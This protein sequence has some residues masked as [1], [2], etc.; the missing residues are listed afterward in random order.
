MVKPRLAAKR[1]KNHNELVRAWLSL[2]GSWQELSQL[3]G[4]LDGIAGIFGIDQRVE[5]KSDNGGYTTEE[6][7]TVDEW[8]GRTP[9]VWRSIED[10]I[11]TAQTMG[12]ERR[13]K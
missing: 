1:D 6:K 8:K 12:K 10:V 13:M 3:P 7:K 9:V 4:A 5:I 2:G 11:H